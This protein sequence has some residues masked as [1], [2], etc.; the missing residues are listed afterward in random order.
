MGPEETQGWERK[1]QLRIIK[2]VRIWLLIV[3]NICTM[4]K[5]CLTEGNNGWGDEVKRGLQEVLMNMGEC[6]CMF[7]YEYLGLNLI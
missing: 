1:R 3:V 7:M 5:V 4:R 2:V 6:V